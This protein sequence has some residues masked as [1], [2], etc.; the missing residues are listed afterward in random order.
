[1]AAVPHSPDLEQK[2]EITDERL[3][4]YLKDMIH[5]WKGVITERGDTLR[6]LGCKQGIEFLQPLINLGI[7]IEMIEAIRKYSPSISP[8]LNLKVG[9]PKP[10]PNQDSYLK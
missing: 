3:M 5:D 4:F 9:V 10:N 1:M 7:T 8:Q 6:F 2:Q